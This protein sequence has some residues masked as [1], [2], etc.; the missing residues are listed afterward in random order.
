MTTDLLTEEQREDVVQ[1]CHRWTCSYLADDYCGCSADNLDREMADRLI[2]DVIGPLLRENA[3]H[4]A[5]VL[6]SL[7]PF[8][9]ALEQMS[10]NLRAALPN[11]ETD[12]A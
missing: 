9:S 7:L 10:H 1:W 5:S 2:E 12:H 6:R 11:E 8:A 3:D 4:S